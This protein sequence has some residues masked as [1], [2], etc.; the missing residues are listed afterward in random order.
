[1]KAALS[2]YRPELAAEWSDENGELTP[3]QVSYGS[4]RKVWWKGKCGHE[5]Q[6]NIKNRVNGAGCPYCTGNKLLKGFNDL[7]SVKQSLVAEWSEKN[8]AKPDE[9]MAGS[10]AKAFWKCRICGGEWEA[11]IADRVAGSGC[12]VCSFARIQ[13]GINDYATWY[14]DLVTEWS[15]KNGDLKP[16]AIS[17]KAR[18]NAWWKCRGCGHE[19]VRSTHCRAKGSG[20]PECR[21]RLSADLQKKKRKLREAFPRKLPQAA[22]RYYAA[23][24]EMPFTWKD[25]VAIGIPLMAWFPDRNSAIET[26]RRKNPLGKT[27][28]PDRIKDALCQRAGIRLVRILDVLED[29]HNGVICIRRLD[30]SNEALSAAVEKAFAI[31]GYDVDVDIDRDMKEIQEDY[32]ENM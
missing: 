17:A 11:R 14:P 13:P 15:K 30:D 23:V 8:G 5:W 1:M 4:N 21:R 22:I 27:E 3:D 6:A 32:L 2:D 16:D 29:N 10:P 26:A 12:P 18:I 25:D 20:C 9:V 28:L 24:G 7:A 19:W 31:I